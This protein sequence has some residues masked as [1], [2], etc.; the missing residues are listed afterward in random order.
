MGQNNGRDLDMPW[1]GSYTGAGCRSYLS[2]MYSVVICET[3]VI[4]KMASGLLE[5]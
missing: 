2:W 1:D 3:I 4:E 5:S